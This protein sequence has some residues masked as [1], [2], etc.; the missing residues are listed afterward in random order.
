MLAWQIWL[1]I[2]GFCFIIEIITVGFL[3]FWFGIAAL[4]VALI[5][6]FVSNM[7]AQTA[8]FIILSAIL[9]LFTRSFAKKVSKSDNIVTNSNR[10]IGKERYRY[11]SH[12]QSSCWP[13]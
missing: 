5:S 11:Q 1:I 3:I 12:K 7:I 13:D 6:L 2:A 9:I 4:A 8:I 10:L